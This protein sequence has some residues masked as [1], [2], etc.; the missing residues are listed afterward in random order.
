MARPRQVTDEQILQVTR[1]CLKEFG[2][3][4]SVEAIAFELGVSAPAL[5]KR[6]GTKRNLLRSSLADNLDMSSVTSLLLIGADPEKDG[7]T[8]L[9]DITRLLSAQMAQALPSV[10][11]MMTSGLFDAPQAYR[12]EMPSFEELVGALGGWLQTGNALG[13]WRM[14][15]TA[16]AAWILVGIT[17][18][19][20]LRHSDAPSAGDEARLAAQ[21]DAMVE[22]LWRGVRPSPQMARATAS[23]KR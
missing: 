19:C 8:Q 10:H 18:S 23:T 20:H 7:L 22:T 3:K 13:L 17:H 15:D 4:V 2:S 11:M 6:F 14:E 16:H 21:L 9:K 5:I 1:N 12:L